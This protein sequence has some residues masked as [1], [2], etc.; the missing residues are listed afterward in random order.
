VWPIT[1]RVQ[2]LNY[3]RVNTFVLL[4]SSSINSYRTTNEISVMKSNLEQWSQKTD[5]IYKIRKVAMTQNSKA[6]LQEGGL[7]W[8]RIKWYRRDCLNR[9]ILWWLVR[10]RRSEVRFIAVVNTVY[11]NTALMRPALLPSTVII[12]WVVASMY[13][14]YS[15]RLTK[16]TT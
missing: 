4:Y 10:N 3:A 15:G 11:L 6:A 2:Y 16:L 5:K 14:E 9:H 8:S 7:L 1:S 13:L 12:H